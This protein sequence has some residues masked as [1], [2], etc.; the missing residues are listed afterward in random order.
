MNYHTS[1]N[2]KRATSNPIASS[3]VNFITLKTLYSAYT[4]ADYKLV[5]CDPPEYPPGGPPDLDS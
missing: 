5:E 2:K 3:H 4:N 1:S